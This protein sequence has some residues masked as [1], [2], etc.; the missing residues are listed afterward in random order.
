M[1][2]AGPRLSLRR[3]D[4]PVG[5][6]SRVFLKE[7]LLEYDQFRNS[8]FHVFISISL[9]V[10]YFSRDTNQ[11]IFYSIN[12]F[13]QSEHHS[14]TGHPRRLCSVAEA[15][16][17]GH[18]LLYEDGA[19]FP[20]LVRWLDCSTNPPSRPPD[21]QYL[22]T[23]GEPISDV[24]CISVPEGRKLLVIAYGS[25]GAQVQTTVESGGKLHSYRQMATA[26]YC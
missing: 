25:R 21:K 8:S 2:S 14:L 24:C 6:R 15:S 23:A 26:R 11:V 17:L 19:H 10:S 9:Q 18:L 4:L 12:D 3:C 22:T 16:S 1:C 13:E 7:C 20:G 5:H